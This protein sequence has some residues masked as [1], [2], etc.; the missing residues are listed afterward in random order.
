MSTAVAPAAFT[1]LGIEALVLGP[2]VGQDGLE[3]REGVGLWRR[4]AAQA[5]VY[6]RVM[7]AA[8]PGIRPDEDGLIAVR[9]VVAVGPGRGGL[10]DRPAPEARATRV[11]AAADAADL[12]L[13]LPPWPG[14]LLLVDDGPGDVWLYLADEPT[15]GAALAR[16]LGRRGRT[17]FARVR[18]RSRLGGWGGA[19]LV[20][21]LALALRVPAVGA[22]VVLLSIAVLLSRR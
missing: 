2:P 17:D 18:R 1:R 3:R 5:P 19:G 11:L 9:V 15:P 14:W 20:A 7:E 13:S 8:G 22:L 21:G 4:D 10:L 6:D 16:F 12:G